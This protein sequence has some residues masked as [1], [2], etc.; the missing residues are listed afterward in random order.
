M[1]KDKDYK[2]KSVD[3]Y[4]GII[5]ASLESKGRYDPSKDITIHRLAAEY[6]IYEKARELFLNEP[7][8]DGR[9]GKVPNAAFDMM[10]KAQGTCTNLEQQLG[11]IG[12]NLNKDAEKE[13]IKDDAPQ[14]PFK[15]LQTAI[16]GVQYSE[17]KKRA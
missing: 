12:K 6:V 13:E 9:T 15:V 10:Q 3:G 11:I 8:V 1:E 2:K 4:A 14:D 7:L 16:N 17:L 5:K